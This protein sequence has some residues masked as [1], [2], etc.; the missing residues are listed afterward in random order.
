MTPDGN[1][2]AEAL[3]A[4]S[5]LAAAEDVGAA[6]HALRAARSALGPSAEAYAPFL[7][8]LCQRAAELAR[9]RH[10]AGCDELTGL[11][12][13]RTFRQALDR[14]LARFRRTG[15]LPSVVLLDLD[16]LKE[17]NDRHGHA[18]GDEAIE[19][20]SG[21]LTATVR[22]TDLAARI[23]GDEFAVLLP[24]TDAFQA[25][26]AGE[27]V[28]AAVEAQRV[29]GVALRI[30]IGVATATEVVGAD[31]LLAQA[32]QRLYGDKARRRKQTDAAA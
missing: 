1:P 26:R 23:G 8:Q 22:A 7:E 12:N 31:H 24:A 16:G 30:S 4:L 18:R 17:I 5:Q 29:A 20:V 27:R 10:L 6:R 3:A 19:R 9:L 25:M 14:E 11:A 28:R 32:D 15:D 21:T 2:S 13:R